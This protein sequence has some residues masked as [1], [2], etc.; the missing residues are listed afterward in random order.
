MNLTI[1]QS[2]NDDQMGEKL[3]R[4]G[5]YHKPKQVLSDLSFVASV[6]G[7]TSDTV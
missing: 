5:L 2:R 7:L 3:F 6:V 1:R 4:R